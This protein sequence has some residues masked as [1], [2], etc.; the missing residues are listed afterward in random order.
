LRY[1]G[2]A[3]AAKEAMACGRQVVTD[4]APRTVDFLA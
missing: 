4:D 2:F 3:V 1:E